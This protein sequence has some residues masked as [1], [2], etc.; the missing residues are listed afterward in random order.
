MDSEEVS[1]QITPEMESMAEQKARDRART[2]RWDLDIAVFLF[3]IL[4][5]VMI[6]LFQEIG[7]EIVA[8]VAIFGLAMVWLVGWR[9]GNQ[10]YGR[11]YREEM[12]KLKR[13]SKATIKETADETDRLP[14]HVFP[15]VAVCPSYASAQNALSVDPVPPAPETSPPIVGGVQA[16]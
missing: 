16:A 6:L 14:S 7:I 12:T 4:I 15:T 5:I 1:E 8:P 9:R 2:Q 11:F 3:A 13:E 10:L